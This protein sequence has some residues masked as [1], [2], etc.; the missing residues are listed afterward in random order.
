[1]SDNSPRSI[2]IPMLIVVFVS[3]C[4]FS[5]SGIA[6][7]TARNNY[8][9]SLE[10]M[11]RVKNYTMA[12]NDAEEFL[13]NLDEIP[14]EELT[15]SFPF[16]FSMEEVAV[17]IAPNE[18]GDDY[19]IKSWSITDSSSWE[20]PDDLNQGGNG[21]GPQGPQA[22]SGDSGGGP[23]G[24]QAPSGDSGGGPQGPQAPME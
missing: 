20:A 11:D 10:R 7:S 24:P 22:P 14:E 5:F 8:E 21:G 16:G 19:I 9:R 13:A 12:C 3:I 23:Q 18:A 4:L 1:M 15:R 6:L 2:G 17:T